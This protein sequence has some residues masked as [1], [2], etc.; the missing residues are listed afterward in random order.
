MPQ[1]AY[2]HI[3]FQY[4]LYIMYKSLFIDLDDTLWAFS[5]NAEDTFR[6]LYDRY[7]FDRYFDRFEQFYD[8][9]R[10]RN[11]ELWVEYGDG[12]ITKEQ[13]NGE[14]FAYPLRAV[15]VDDADLSRRYS[16]DFF[17]LIPTCSKLM[18]HAREALERLV[19]GHR[20]YILSNGFR[21]LQERKMRAA[22]IYDY[23]DR[24]ILSEDIGVHKPYPEIFHFA[25]SA[26]QSDL[27]TSLMIG[28]S[29]EADICGARA[30]GMKQLYYNPARRAGLPFRP[31]HEIHTWEEI[32]AL[33]I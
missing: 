8:L 13:L 19:T 21:E 31:T 11:T 10:R 27:R 15:G 16:D 29:W 1:P 18:P 20:L 24:I 5:E 28:D 25:L 2:R 32:D 3:L 14:R 17:A 22:G 23:F 6:L 33:G 7:G 26:T 12:R 9:Y 30:V 4:T